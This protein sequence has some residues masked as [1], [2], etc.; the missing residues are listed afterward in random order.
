MKLFPTAAPIPHLIIEDF[1]NEIE[2][3]QMIWNE[4]DW[5]TS[6]NKLQAPEQTGSA[7]T[8][9]G[10][11]VKQNRGVFFE[12]FFR[13]APNSDIVKCTD[14]VWTTTICDAMESLTPTFRGFRRAGMCTTMLSYYQNGDYYLPHIDNTMFTLLVWLWKEPK[15]WTGGEFILND[16][17]YTVPMRNNSAILFPSCYV[18]SVNQVKLEGES[19]GLDY[20]GNGR[21]CISRF[22]WIQNQAE[23]GT[24]HGIEPQMQS[25]EIE[26]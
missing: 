16:R 21:Y 19:P 18:H 10:E 24:Y 26:N 3:S 7:A 8:M 22:F 20:T 15:K 17:E 9:E 6:P 1:Y 13:D 23:F 11:V 2:L 5:M 12:E 14:K 25:Y 4:L